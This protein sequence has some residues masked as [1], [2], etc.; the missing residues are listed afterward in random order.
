[1]SSSAKML[2]TMNQSII[3]HERE[4]TTSK[5]DVNCCE[6]GVILCYQPDLLKVDASNKGRRSYGIRYKCDEENVAFFGRPA[7]VNENTAIHHWG[8]EFGRELDNPYTAHILT[9]IER[10]Y[11]PDMTNCHAIIVRS[12]ESNSYIALHVPPMVIDNMYNFMAKQIKST[13]PSSAH[14]E[15]IAIDHSPRENFDKTPIGLGRLPVGDLTL[16]SI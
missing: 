7:E 4:I 16:F 13:F 1:M 12:P 5:S 10:F 3:D 14:L 11:F 6:T 9:E 2:E 15:F 8:L